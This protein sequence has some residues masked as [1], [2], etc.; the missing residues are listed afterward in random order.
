MSLNWE[1]KLGEYNFEL[2]P[3]GYIPE[4][5]S[6]LIANDLI[7][8]DLHANIYSIPKKEFIRRLE[9]IGYNKK[10]IED[11]I[12]EYKGNILKKKDCILFSDEEYK[13]FKP[14]ESYWEDL[15]EIKYENLSKSLF[16][17]YANKNNIKNYK[18]IVALFQN[19]GFDY[20][21]EPYFD[22]LILYYIFVKDSL[23]DNDNI[24]I[25]FSE[26][27]D[28][29]I[30]SKYKFQ[31]NHF[32]D[33]IAKF[34]KNTLVLNQQFNNEENLNFEF[35][36]VNGKVLNSISENLQ[37]YIIGFLNS[38][39]G[40]IIWGIEDSGKIT[41]FDA[42]RGL[43]DKIRKNIYSII[44]SIQPAVALNKVTVAFINLITN[45][46]IL[47][48]KICLSVSIEKGN[49][50]EMFFSESGKTWIKLEGILKELK[51]HELFKYIVANY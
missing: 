42:D 10:N 24:V 28:S 7:E 16:E 20:V 21:I 40:K 27:A 44:S 2:G 38:D 46:I 51:G 5:T 48:N 31:Y 49:S 25:D 29:E 18:Y 47:E 30:W 1:I 34:N 15:K 22:P 41:G 43:R 4:I 17:V 26:M 8:N 33:T 32:D 39:G 12:N 19:A 36:S 11:S 3:D 13:C 35:K 14:D 23:K 37:K 50:N 6:L 9:L 45:G